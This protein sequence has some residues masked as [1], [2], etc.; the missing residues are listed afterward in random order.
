[1]KARAAAASRLV[2][3]CTAC[4]H[5]RRR[6]CQPRAAMLHVTVVVG[7]KASSGGACLRRRRQGRLLLADNSAVP[8]PLRAAGGHA[9]R[10]QERKLGA[11]MPASMLQLESTQALFRYCCS[12]I[13][14]L[15]MRTR[16]SPFRR[17]MARP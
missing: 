12:S 13:F 7:L 10:M 3:A 15:F 8:A 6:P 5:G 1:M 9:R 16:F 2:T 17:V 11:V 14:H 4:C